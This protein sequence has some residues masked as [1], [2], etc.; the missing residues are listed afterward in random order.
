MQRRISGEMLAGVVALVL[1][2]VL[3]LARGARDVPPTPSTPSSYD[4]G[5]YGYAAYYDLLKREGFTVRRFERDHHFLSETGTGTLIVAQSPF[6]ALANRA[7]GVTRNDVI[8]IKVWVQGGGH[9]IVLAPPYGGDLD[10]LAG[11][12][13]SRALRKKVSAVY[14]FADLAQV[15]GVRS[16]SGAVREVFPWNAS[17]KALPLLAVSGGAVALTYPFGR[18][19]VTAVTDPAI[20]S[21][22]ML[23]RRDNARFAVQL[24]AAR[25]GAIAFD[26]TVHGFGTSESLWASLPA[27]AQTGAALAALALLLGITGNM[28]R[29][30]PPIPPARAPERD[31]SAYITSMANLMARAHAKQGAVRDTADAALRAVRRSLGLSERTP[32]RELLTRIGDAPNGPL[33][34]ELDRLRDVENP[35]NAELMR[36]GTLA[37]HLRKET[38]T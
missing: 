8:S 30:A 21:N 11:I 31:S 29:F 6:D 14:P 2:V 20:F 25:P 12:P 16:V 3:A 27:S 5:R 28:L 9:L 24:L 22:A 4:T 7:A 26:E 36:A 34:L 32:L 33:V 37:A 35:T 15:R 13:S 1:I 23:A 10:A 19:R 18:G 17:P 38:G